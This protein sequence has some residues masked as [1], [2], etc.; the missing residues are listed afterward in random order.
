MKLTATVRR[1]LY[2]SALALSAVAVLYGFI[3]DQEAV[4]WLAVLSPWIGLAR[5]NVQ[6]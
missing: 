1:R 5:A 3:S 4:A 2:D 6:D